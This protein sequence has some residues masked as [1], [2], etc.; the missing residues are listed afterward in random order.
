M[1]DMKYLLLFEKFQS[2]KLSKTL[3]FIKDQDTQSG[4]LDKIKRITNAFDFPTSELSDDMFEYLPFKSALKVNK[5]ISELPTKCDAESEWIKGEFCEEGKVKRTWGKGYRTVECEKCGGTGIKKTK[6]KPE[7]YCIKFWFDKD[8][9]FIT[10]TGTDGTKRI[11]DGSNSNINNVDFS[12]Y[13]EKESYGPR[14]VSNSPLKTGDKVKMEKGGNLLFG[15]FWRDNDGDVCFFIGRRSD[16]LTGGHP[17]R[18]NWQRYGNG[19]WGLGQSDHGTL[20]LLEPKPT[21]E[22]EPDPKVEVENP[23]TWN[24]KAEIS[25]YGGRD[26]IISLQNGSNVE[27]NLK[28][29]HFAIIMY[30]NKLRASGFTT[31]SDIKTQREISKEGTLKFEND[32][33]IKKANIERYINKLSDKFDINAG[34][35]GITKII[36]RLLGGRANIFYYVS[37]E[38]RFS[39]LNDIISNVYKF[40]KNNSSAKSATD[41]IKYLINNDF[42]SNLKINNNITHN[43]NEIIKSLKADPEYSYLVEA[44]NAL[45]TLNE[46]VYNKINVNVETIQDMEILYSKLMSIRQII[47]KDRYSIRHFSN[48][49]SYLGETGYRNSLNYLTGYIN[50]DRVKD[51]LDDVKIISDIIDKI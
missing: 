30:I 51:L 16:G 22:K 1:K 10:L 33:D 40:M 6:T 28:N 47:R 48:Y 11:E 35:S 4:F 45:D 24:Y 31:G 2:S 23:Y 3:G 44:V 15:T 36:P 17:S 20:T 38:R 42:K 14:D 12:K 7:V 5:E 13:I 26:S 46:K 29:A 9:K 37:E 50:E 39:T 41:N 21:I 43:K 27:D 18:G 49:L 8:G 25:R 32:A 34:I 19:S